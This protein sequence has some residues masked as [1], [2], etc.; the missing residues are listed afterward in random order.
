MCVIYTVLMPSV[1]IQLYRTVKLKI[2]KKR[3]FLCRL[4]QVLHNISLTEQ[5]FRTVNHQKYEIG[6]EMTQS[7]I[8]TAGNCGVSNTC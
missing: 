2:K 4:M 1:L 3:V 5:K 8:N 6:V 7:V